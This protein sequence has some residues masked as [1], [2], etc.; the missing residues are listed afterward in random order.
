M[1]KKNYQSVL[2]SIGQ[3]P[4]IR[5][6][7]VT[8]DS[9]HEFYAKVEYFNPGGSVK[10]RIGLAMIRAAEARGQLRPGATIIEATSGNTGIGLAM[11]A[12]LAGYRCIFVMPDK[13]SQEKR[14]ILKAYGA[15]VI[16]TPTG[17]A[18]ED[19]LSHYSVAK[20]IHESIPNSYYTN[21]YHN[22]DNPEVHF[23]TTGPEIWEQTQ[24]RIDVLVDGAGTGGTLTGCARFLKT[25]NPKVKIICGD[26]I[27]SIL[28]DLYYLGKVV[29][30]PAPYFVEGI[31]ED[32]LP[33]NIDLK[34]YDGFVRV[35]D[36][37]AFQMTRRLALEEALCVGP[38]SGLAMVA[39]LRY[40][41]ELKEKSRIVVVF[42]DS[43]RAY[44][45]KVFN[46]QWMLKNNL[47][48]EAELGNVYNVEL[49]AEQ[50][51]QTMSKGGGHGE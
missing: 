40:A 14:D 22:P 42:P 24:G 8:K 31:G 16:I 10:D 43:G 13:I 44:L 23:Q 41:Q 12:T 5:L 46:D 1:E 7:S 29:E 17:V 18:P 33:D 28:Y 4:L 2:E 26:P 34:I 37:D 32:M 20:R 3:T 11:V 6:N 51:L 15:K 48:S 50:F 47:V 36:R 21:Q 27:G 49:K 25:Q 45:S 39:A 19:P 30:P 9:P 38:S 35:N